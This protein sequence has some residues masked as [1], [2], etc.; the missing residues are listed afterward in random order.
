M[1]QFARTGATLL[2]A[3]SLW[4]VHATA[5]IQDN[6]ADAF[7]SGF[8]GVW[9]GPPAGGE[10]ALLSQVAS[11]GWRLN[12]RWMLFSVV[13]RSQG[14]ARKTFAAETYVGYDPEA[15]RYDAY[16]FDTIGAARFSGERV[17]E[18]SLV[19]TMTAADGHIERLTLTLDSPTAFTRLLETSRDGS[20]FTTFSS[21]RY[22]KRTGEAVKRASDQ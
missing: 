4:T 16:V 14:K 7:L 15:R 3:L 8:A 5:Q 22:T 20:Q 17:G 12:N 21:V 18:K 11:N 10:A 19:L 9:D 1:H 2:I 13:E 6:K